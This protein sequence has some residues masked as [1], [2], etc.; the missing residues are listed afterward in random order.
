MEVTS[1]GAFSFDSRR[2]PGFAKNLWTPSPP[3]RGVEPPTIARRLSSPADRGGRRPDSDETCAAC[4]IA[5]RIAVS[6]TR[7]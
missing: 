7:S 3:P 6:I 5:C 1:G 2:R 4:A